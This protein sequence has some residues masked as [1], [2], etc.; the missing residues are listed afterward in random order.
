MISLNPSTLLNGTGIDVTSLVNQVLSQENGQ[1]TLLQQQQ[2]DLQ[3]QSSLLTGINN[4]LNSLSTAVNS[5]TDVLGP[6][7]A[8]SATSSQNGILTA[9]AQ[10]SAT[11]GT[12]TVVVSTLA[13]QGTLY[14]DAVKDANTSILPS[15]AQSAD[16]AFQVGGSNGPTH[17]ITITAGSNDTLTSLA[18]YINSQNWGVTARVLTDASGARLAIYSNGSGSTGALAITN[19]TSSLNFNSPVGGTDATFTVDGVPFSSTSNTVNDA[20]PGVTLNLLGAYPGVQVQVAVATDSTQAVQAI[21]DFVSAYNAVIADLNKQFTVDPNTNSEGPLASDSSLRSLQSSLLTNATYSP[22]SSTLYTNSIKDANT[23][24]LPAGV[25]GADF[26]FQVGGSN[27]VTHDVAISA[28][29]NDTLASMASY[30]NQQGWG[31]SATVVTDSTGS[32]LEV[33]SPNDGTSNT[34]SLVSNTTKLSFTAAE[35]SSYFSLQ[36]L[37]ITMNNDGTLSIN[38]SQ[39]SSAIANN[40]AQVLS[41]FQN[42][43]GT[44]FANSF[45]TQLQNLT[46]PTQGLL[47]MDLAQNQAEQQ[48]LANSLLDLQDRMNAEQQQLQ[49]QFSQV[50]AL[51]QAFPYQLQAIQMELGINP[52]TNSNGT[53]SRG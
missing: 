1:T 53:S 16:L 11:A 44:G 13:T 20:I 46:D 24:I 37:G 50:S 43:A 48:D 30:I 36:G 27:G 47:N 21:G 32:H 25:Q 7:T 41:F 26:Q 5:L 8:M 19:N 40:A 29:N 49:T 18:S 6:L 35:G 9:S 39:L 3:G 23:S 51:L 52:S 28:G 33:S 15:N 2:T 22:P 17:D 10:T 42:T 34:L 12:H 31:V 45:A 4:D 38:S 14:T